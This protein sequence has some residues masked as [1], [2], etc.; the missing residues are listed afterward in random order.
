MWSDGGELVRP[1]SPGAG[2]WAYTDIVGGLKLP[3]H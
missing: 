3:K 1:L 2:A